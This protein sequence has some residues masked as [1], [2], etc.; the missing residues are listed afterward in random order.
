MSK[1]FHRIVIQIDMRDLT[2]TGQ[3]IGIDCE[4]VILRRNLN[5]SRKQILHRVIPPVM[6]KRQLVSAASECEPHQLMPKANSEYRIPPD[7]FSYILNDISQR[8]R[9][10]GAV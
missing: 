2:I 4:S 9:I 3:R 7:Q 6:P 5:P 10:A 8:F 1:P